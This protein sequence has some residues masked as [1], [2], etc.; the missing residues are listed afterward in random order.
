MKGRRFKRKWTKRVG[1]WVYTIT[2]TVTG[3]RTHS[4]SKKEA[5]LCLK[6]LIRNMDVFAQAQA[7]IGEHL[8]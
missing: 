6:W 2:D 3:S 4:H 5:E 7:L 8:S 1:E